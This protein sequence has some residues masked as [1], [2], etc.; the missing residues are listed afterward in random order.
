MAKFQAIH[1]RGYKG[2]MQAWQRN[3]LVDKEGLFFFFAFLMLI[4]T[5]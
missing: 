1:S 2:H 4:V 3:Y 5:I